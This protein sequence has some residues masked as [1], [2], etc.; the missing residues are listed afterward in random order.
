MDLI[1]QA[2]IFM[3]PSRELIKSEPGFTALEPADSNGGSHSYNYGVDPNA[4]SVL[5]KLNSGAIVAAAPVPV[6][7]RVVRE[8]TSF[9]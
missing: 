6:S 4:D 9:T 3:K 8:R 7:R 5:G 1:L 2:E